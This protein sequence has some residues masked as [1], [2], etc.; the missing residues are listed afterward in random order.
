MTECVVPER[1]GRL[2]VLGGTFD[3]VHFGHLVA[4][5]EVCQALGLDEVIFVPTG[6]P[7]QKFGR[8]LAP[9]EDRYAMTVLATA[10]NP[11]FSVS[12][13][14]MDRPGRTYTVD[15]LRDL[16][17]SRGPS[18]EFF[19]IMGADALRGIGTWRNPEE[20]LALAKFV[21]CTRA[22]H[23]MTAEMMAD[24]RFLRVAIPALEISS[25]MCRERVAAGLPINYLVPEAVAQYIAKRRLY[26][27]NGG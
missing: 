4:A 24:E 13:V 12:R 1:P 5:S 10:S 16:R 23:Q 6:Q 20:L 7:W 21:G 8:E 25:T 9:V 11:L 3:P 18:A 19:F 17:A 14:D 2:G 27:A 22:G 26:L 15:T